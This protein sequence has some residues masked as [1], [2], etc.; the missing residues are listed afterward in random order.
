[1]NPKIKLLFLALGL[2]IVIILGVTLFN[3]LSQ[4]ST[5][6]A[7]PQPDENTPLAIDFTVDDMSGNPATL[8]EHMDKPVLLNFWASWCPP[9]TEEMPHFQAM[10]EQYG[11]RVNFMMINS[12]DGDRET[13]ATVKQF[14]ELTGYTFPV[15]LDTHG[16]Q[17]SYTY[18]ITGIPQTF[19]ID[20]Q[21][22]IVVHYPGSIPQE[23]LQQGLEFLLGLE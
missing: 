18:N 20:T 2:V 14:L 22:R 23:P 15:Y 9:C 6:P 17:A 5:L 13:P 8:F 3:S 7:L 1:M 21:G 19:F 4:I 12:T 16:L 10:F 11:D